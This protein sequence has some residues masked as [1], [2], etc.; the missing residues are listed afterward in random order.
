MKRVHD[1]DFMLINDSMR[2]VS[3]LDAPAHDRQSKDL[4]RLEY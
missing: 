2:G 3:I 1:F 4:E